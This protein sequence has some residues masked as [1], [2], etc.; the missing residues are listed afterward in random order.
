MIL[1]LSPAKTLDYESPLPDLAATRPRFAEEAIATAQAASKLSARKLGKLMSI[2]DK[3]SKLN[4]ERYSDF[5]GQEERPAIYAFAGDVYTGL[6]ARTLDEPAIGFAQ[7]H[8]RILSGL[9]GLLRPL[10]LI[11]PYR[12][13]MGTRWA[14]GR[15]K[16]LYEH[17]GN[18]ISDVIAADLLAEGSDTMVNCASREYWHAIDQAPPKGVR[19]ITIDFREDGPKGL[20]FISF[21]AKRARGMMARWMCEHRITNPDDLRGFDSD[22]YAFTADGSDESVWRFVRKRRMAA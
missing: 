19:I 17:W 12:L 5:A 8:V 20:S 3:L 7:D 6:E 9:Y 22:G 18:R 21:N 4:A 15:K 1:L 2:S 13:E 10:D 11:R 16:N 14:P